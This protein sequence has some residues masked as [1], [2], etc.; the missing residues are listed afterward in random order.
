MCA[1]SALRSSAFDG[2]HPTLRQTPPQYLLLDDGDLAGRAARRGSPRRTHRDRH[3]GRRHRSVLMARILGGADQHA[4]TGPRPLLANSLQQ[5][6]QRVWCRKSPE[7]QV[8]MTTAPSLE[9]PGALT[10]VRRSLT[11]GEW[12]RISG[13]GRVRRG[14]ARGRLGALAAIVAPAS[15]QVGS[16]RLRDRARP[17][18]VHPRDAARVRRRPHRRHRQHHPQADGGGQE[19]VTVG[20]WFSL[21]H[22]SHRLRAVPAA[23]LRG[24][25]RW[26]GR[27]RATAPRCRASPALIGT[28]VSGV[29]LYVIGILNLVILVGILKVFRDMRRGDY[30]EAAL[31]EHLNNRGLMN[32]FLGGL[33]K[34]VTKPWQIYP[35]RAAVRARLR[36]RDRGRPAGARRRRGGVPRCRGTPSSPCR[37]CSPP[38]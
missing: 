28:L 35:D 12:T 8:P 11:R 7:R 18:G 20:F 32:R 16:S 9:R 31:E 5:R 15:Y 19:P 1:S 27:S 34:S 2:M 30:D 33:T 4:R 6:S 23:R 29:F 3:R 17:H 22:S 38:A 25:A 26:P 37:S 36:H 14:A 10:R 13:D 24:R 21:G